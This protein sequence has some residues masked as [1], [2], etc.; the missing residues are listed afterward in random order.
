MS[1]PLARHP[2]VC[3]TWCPVK[4][5]SALCAH[6]AHP[7]PSGALRGFAAGRGGR[8]PVQPPAPALASNTMP[9]RLKLIRDRSIVG[10]PDLFG[11]RG[12]R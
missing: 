11:D 2:F 5:C 12:A 9:N 10:T 8:A 7:S 4:G 3:F 1:H 6:E